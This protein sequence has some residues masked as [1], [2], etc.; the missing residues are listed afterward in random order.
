MRL[1]KLLLPGLLSISLLSGCS[2]FNSEEDVVKMSPLPSVTNQFTPSTAWSTSVGHGTGEFYSSLHPAFADGIIY[3]ADRNGTV[4]ALNTGDGKAI[5]SVN[6]AEKEGWFSRQSAL[7]SGG[8]TV[9]G[10]HIYVGSEK[11]SCMH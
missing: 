7:L 11:H 5:W 6:L 2:L 4:S 1:R 8:L 3:A 9:S 10:G